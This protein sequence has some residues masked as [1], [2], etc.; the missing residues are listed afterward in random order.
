MVGDGQLDVEVAGGATAPTEEVVA[1]GLEAAKPFLRVLCQAQ[2]E[3][4]GKSAKPVA[5]FKL[6]PPYQQDAYD[7][8]AGLV[9]DELS[10]ALTIA[11][12]NIS[13]SLSFSRA[14][15]GVFSPARASQRRANSSRICTLLCGSIT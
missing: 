2:N 4:A 15:G 11:A 13:G 12:A 1:E 7:A 3:L 10:Q 6:F 5:E 14:S 9:W 8:V